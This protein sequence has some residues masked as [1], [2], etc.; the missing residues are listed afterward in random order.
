VDWAIIARSRTLLIL[1]AVDCCHTFVSQHSD[2]CSHI[3]TEANNYKVTHLDSSAVERLYLQ[4][5]CQYGSKVALCLI[6]PTTSVLQELY[7]IIS[8]VWFSS[9]EYLEFALD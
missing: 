6:G 5:A 1:A 3:G 2:L 8:S 7:R 9:R 4:Q